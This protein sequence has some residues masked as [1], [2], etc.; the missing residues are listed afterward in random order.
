M[1]IL[2]K[3]NFSIIWKGLLLFFFSLGICNEVSFAQIT[4]TSD[5]PSGRDVYDNFNGGLEKETILDATNPME[6][7]NRLRRA[8]AMD[9]ATSPSDAVDA[10]L[11]AL[12]LDENAESSSY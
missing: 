1:E 2:I 7:M 8:T 5:L 11:K 3:S 10:A 4:E 6:L 9:D 12:E